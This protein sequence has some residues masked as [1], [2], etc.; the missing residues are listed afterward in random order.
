MT[1]TIAVVVTNDNIT[2]TKSTTT[3]VLIYNDRIDIT[4]N[5]QIM[6]NWN[7]IDL[8]KTFTCKLKVIT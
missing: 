8:N 1:K 2:D 6:K 7:K 3:G 4:T 5:Q